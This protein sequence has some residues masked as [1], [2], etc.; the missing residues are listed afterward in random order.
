[1]QKQGFENYLIKEEDTLLVALKKIDQNNKGFLIVLNQ[2]NIVVGTLTDGDT[3]RS[4]I[5]GATTASKVKDIYQKK[6]TKISTSDGIEKVI[7][8][9]KSPKID[10]LPIIEMNG[11]LKNIITK[12][13][14]HTLLLEDP[15]FNL[16][17]DF[18]GLDDSLLD[19]EIYNRPWGLY[20]TTFLNNYSRSKIIMVNPKGILSL[21][22]H[23]RR[24]EHWV[25]INGEGR[26]T[27]GDSVKNVHAGDFIYIPKGCKHR[28]E[29]PSGSEYLMVAEVQLGDYFG[30]DDIIRYEDIYGRV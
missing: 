2:T 29:N 28:L 26:V 4:F 8:L 21:Q 1:M 15:N 6:F 25:I 13:N 10:F 3:R 24:E 12:T 16:G 19:H 22:E 11:E 27:L 7:E 14:M 20:K 5:N 30:E 17:Y 23:K 9:F 18:L